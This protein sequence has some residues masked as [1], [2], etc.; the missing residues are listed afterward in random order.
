MFIL[1]AGPREGGSYTYPLVHDLK[2]GPPPTDRAGKNRYTQGIIHQIEV[3][4]DITSVFIGYFVVVTRIIF[5]FSRDLPCRSFLFRGVIRDPQDTKNSPKS[6][7]TFRSHT[8]AKLWL[9][10]SSAKR[11]H[12][13]SR[14][15]IVRLNRHSSA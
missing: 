10:M 15:Q 5:L 12:S 14:L 8:C 9:P 13:V 1:S 6:V 11:N 7:R 2:P 3:L 4:V